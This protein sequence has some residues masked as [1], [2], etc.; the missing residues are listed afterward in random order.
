MRW[1][2]FPWPSRAERRQRV[3]QARAG[4]KAARH[5]AAKAE[6]LSRDLKRIA[7]EN[8]FAEAVLEGWVS[9]GGGAE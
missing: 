5:E 3:E 1:R 7:E 9:R 4:A 8:G 2:V 6:R